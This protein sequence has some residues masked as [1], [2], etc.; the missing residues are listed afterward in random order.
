MNELAGTMTS[1][2]GPI[3]AA[4]SISSRAS[5]PLATPIA[6]RRPHQAASSSSKAV[7]TSPPMKPVV[8]RISAQPA[9]TSSAT[10]W[11]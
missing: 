5:V 8:S 4:R 2:P 7:T 6:S 10:S 1:S 3:P 9:A 11:C